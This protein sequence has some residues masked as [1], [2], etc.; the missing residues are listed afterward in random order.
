MIHPKDNARRDPLELF[1]QFRALRLRG[2]SAVRAVNE[3]NQFSKSYRFRVFYLLEHGDPC[4]V[5][6]VERGTIPLTAATHIA[7]ATLPELQRILTDGYISGTVSQRQIIAIQQIIDRHERAKPVLSP[8][9]APQKASRTTVASMMHHF[10]SETFAQ[11]LV[12][13]KA[14]LAQSHLQAIV[15]ALRRLIAEEPF[16]ALLRT[17]GILTMPNWLAERIDSPASDAETT[18]R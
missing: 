2:Y 18:V 9:G 6:E 16:V 15:G 17:E 12:L 8:L 7:R 13:E 3:S 4:L 1:R 11:K 10:E 5:V 14:R